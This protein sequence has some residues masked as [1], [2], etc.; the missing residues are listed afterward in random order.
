MNRGFGWSSTTSTPVP[1]LARLR[2]DLTVRLSEP[3]ILKSDIERY[4][5]H[6]LEVAVV[7]DSVYQEEATV[8]CRCELCECV[9]ASLADV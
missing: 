9:V 2:Y 3:R 4:S 7:E 8:G 5:Y 6:A 1:L